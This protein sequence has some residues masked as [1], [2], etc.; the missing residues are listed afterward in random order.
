MPPQ[1]RTP[2]GDAM[3]HRFPEQ[4]IPGQAQDAQPDVPAPESVPPTDTPDDKPKQRDTP[5][6]KTPPSPEDEPG[7]RY[8]PI[9][10]PGQEHAPERV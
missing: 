4:K 2:L 8:I 7:R 1:D 9:D 3:S 6:K 5:D 10:L